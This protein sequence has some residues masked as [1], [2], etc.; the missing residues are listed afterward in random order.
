MAGA[1]VARR[2][3]GGRKV[4][5]RAI[6]AALDGGAY[7]TDALRREMPLRP[8]S[9][10]VPEL[11]R[12]RGARAL[13]WLQRLYFRNQPALYLAVPGL[14]FLV[15]GVLDIVRSGARSEMEHLA[16]THQV[17]VGLMDH[18]I[19][20][21]FLA[22]LAYYL[23]F[24]RKLRAA[25]RTYRRI[26]AEEL[27]ESAQRRPA[28]VRR[29]RVSLFAEGIA[30]SFD[31]A[32]GIVYGRTGMG[33]TS[34]V[35]GLVEDLAKK[36]LVPVPVRARHD[37]T[38]S[39]EE[40]AERAFRK[41]VDTKVSSSQQ[42]E[43]IWRRARA[44]R[45]V[46]VIV[47][48][49]DDDIVAEWWEDDGARLQKTVEELVAHNLAV[50]L[51]TTRRLPLD[52]MVTLREDLD[53]FTRAEAE[54]YIRL[55]E[56]SKRIDT[57]KAHE[58][59]EALRRLRDPVD[60]S[61]VAPFYLELIEG[62]R[63]PLGELPANRDLWR[64]AVLE[65]YLEAL[66]EGGVA[67]PR[68]PREHEPSELRRRGREAMAAATALARALKVEDGDL[69]VDIGELRGAKGR[70]VK[71][72]VDF[73]LLRC[74]GQRVGF[75]AD[76]LAAYTIGK[77]SDDAERLLE[78]VSRI[79]KREDDRGREDR[80]PIMAL[81][82]WEYCHRERV[83]SG[84]FE[85]FLRRID[86]ERWTR[87]AVVA[88]AIRIATVC[89]IEGHAATLARCAERC[90]AHV[91]AI[92]P[93]DPG[94]WRREELT[95]LVRALAEWQDPHA[96]AVLWRLASSTATGLDWPAAKALAMA[97][98]NPAETL[99]T[100]IGRLLELAD[101]T[102]P[103]ALS[104]HD[105]KLGNE[106]A[107]LAWVLPALRD[108]CRE[109]F[110]HVMRLCLA[111]VMS[112]LRGEV[113]LA[114]GIK[115]ALLNGRCADENLTDAIGLLNTRRPPRD[116]Y[117]RSWHA[118][119]LLVQAMLAHVWVSDSSVAGELD[120]HLR[121]L[122][123]TER[124][125]LVLRAIKLVREGIKASEDPQEKDKLDRYIW[126]HE[127]E[128]VSWVGQGKD[129]LAQLAADVVLLSNMSYELRKRYPTDADHAAT[130]SDLPHCIRNSSQRHL[131]NEQGGCSCP[132]RL[133][134][135]AEEPVREQHAPFEE[136]FCR[137]QVRLARNKGPPP[138]VGRRTRISREALA[139]FWE[140]QASAIARDHRRG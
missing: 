45:S 22:G 29:S 35:V 15:L 86:D 78:A 112:P 68:K 117:I 55:N 125:P 89:G 99:D 110:A 40:D 58:A 91:E 20:T 127:K 4:G 23:L 10:S 118:R 56:E 36:K 135:G 11:P 95:K 24:G 13:R 6:S 88:A 46:V 44:S 136:S 90:I 115:H 69:A 25:I 38:L 51:A 92:A 71:Q 48:G 105:D 49:I 80:Y 138:W 34:F 33:R 47:D 130:R 122:E 70:Q 63:G 14:A 94:A 1:N 37:A 42:G 84:V 106:I 12:T 85:E 61:L 96:H 77:T 31:P 5:E 121:M 39:F 103:A 81:L 128:A 113:S 8:T 27:V 98:G 111:E 107:A 28:V 137:Q 104:L 54:K 126:T 65:R 124:H 73:G 129:E 52:G 18:L 21:G 26:P 74:A 76:D 131:I 134:K 100:E 109:Q 53:R 17:T 66:P 7:L 97:S 60:E 119:I 43:A 16:S 82:F 64:A 139:H 102:E 19:V 41:R 101:R 50:V 67:Q 9:R 3:P 123:G 59:I 30:R 57:T 87:P 2:V 62:L 72:A 116:P 140:S 132:H 75:T 133:C 120:Q 32:V 83:G 114:Q 93:D 108:R 79:A